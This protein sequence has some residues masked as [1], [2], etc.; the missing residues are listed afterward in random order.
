MRCGRARSRYTQQIPKKIARPVGKPGGAL[1]GLAAGLR[2]RQAA[3]R[4]TVVRPPGIANGPCIAIVDGPKS[5]SI[6]PG[7]SLRRTVRVPFPVKGD[8]P[9]RVPVY[10]VDDGKP[11][12]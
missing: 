8:R 5:R 4:F 1:L 7:L 11:G 3:T 2:G 9:V 12:T 6:P 10:R